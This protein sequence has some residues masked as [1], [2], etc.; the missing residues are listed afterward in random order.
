MKVKTVTRMIEIEIDNATLLSL[1]VEAVYSDAKDSTGKDRTLYRALGYLVGISD[2]EAVKMAN[3][4]A[5]EKE[6]HVTTKKFRHWLPTVFAEFARVTMMEADN[7][8]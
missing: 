3:S 2:V 8:D 1:F 6:N 5:A 4:L 7:E